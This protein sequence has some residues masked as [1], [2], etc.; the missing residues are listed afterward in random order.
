MR[1]EAAELHRVRLPLR[2]PLRAAHGVEHER[3]TI[4]LRLRTDLGDGWGECSAL[5]TP[6]YLPDHLAG[7]ELVLTDHVLPQV[8][9]AADIEPGTL[10]AVVRLAGWPTVRMAVSTALL[11]ARLRVAG[12]SLADDLGVESD[13]VPVGA[14]LGLGPVDEL[15]ERA[16]QLAADG[17]GRIKLKIRPGEDLRPLAAVRD[18]VGGDVELH[19]DANGSYGPAD[20]DA[21]LALDDLGLGLLEQPYAADRLTASA[22]LQ[23][24]MRTPIALDE[25]IDSPTRAADA[26]ELGACRSLSCKPARLGGIDRAVAVHDLCVDRG[27]SVWVGGMWESGFARQIVIT[28]AGLPGMTEVGDVGPA[29]DYLAEDVVGSAPAD[30]GV[31]RVHRG[32]GVAPAPVPDDLRRWREALVEVRP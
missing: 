30:E 25:S 20:L 19:A 7:A 15:V 28:L 22:A 31:V 16:E 29:T 2:T 6:T 32:P 12:R 8:L 5:S 23:R 18:A 4:L 21:L 13:V 26:L 24:E 11:D 3:R 10:D 17:V 14:V 27:A 9:A 1:V